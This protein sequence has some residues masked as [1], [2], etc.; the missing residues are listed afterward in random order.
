VT[1]HHDDPDL[2]ELTPEDQ[3]NAMQNDST[4]FSDLLA[5][6]GYRDGD[7]LTVNVK[8]DG[9]FTTAA[10]SPLKQIAYD[11]LQYEGE[12]VDLWFGLN[13][14]RSD[15]HDGSRGKDSDITAV[16][17]FNVDMDVKA[18]AFR[19][20]GELVLMQGVVEGSGLVPTA[21][22]RTGHGLC[23][24]W[25]VRDDSADIAAATA[26]GVRLRRAVESLA[27]PMLKREVRLDNTSSVTRIV[28]VPGTTNW[29]DA[30][31]PAPTSWEE[32][33]GGGMT[34]T[35][36]GLA[37]LLDEMG[38]PAH[39]EDAD[40]ELGD[41]ADFD[42]WAFAESG[43]GYSATMTRNW[44]TETPSARHPWLINKMVRLHCAAR[45][46]CLTRRGYELAL[47]GVVDR[48]E[49][50]C[51]NVEPRRKPDRHE[52]RDAVRYG[53]ARAAGKTTEQLSRELGDHEHD[54]TDDWL[55]TGTPGT[56]TV[57]S[58]D[59]ET[60]SMEELALSLFTRSEVL[61]SIH[62]HAMSRLASPLAVLGCCMIKALA[63]APPNIV[64]AP[65]IG[66]VA[67]PN[68]YLALVGGSGGG[69]GIAWDVAMDE[70]M[71]GGGV[72]VA[73]PST[74]EGL[75][76]MFVK[77]GRGADAEQGG[78]QYRT[79]AVA[80]VD[81]VSTL[82]ALQARSGNKLASTL[83]T[84]W[85]GR[86]GGGFT[87]TTEN[88]IVLPANS[89]RFCMV[90]GVQPSAAGVLFDD[91]GAGTPQRFW[92]MPATD[93]SIVDGVTEPAPLGWSNPFE[94]YDE[95]GHGRFV[96]EVPQHVW[97]FVRGEHVKRQRGEGDAL[98]GHAL[99]SRLK[100]AVAIASLHRRVAVTDED[101]D[102]S[103]D[104]MAISDLVRQDVLDEL[105]QASA[106][107]AKARGFIK[108]VEDEARDDYLEQR[109]AKKVER[110]VRLIATYLERLGPET[111]KAI[112]P[113][114][115]SRDRDV[116]QDAW[117]IALTRG[118]IRQRGD[119]LYEATTWEGGSGGS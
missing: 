42:T 76:A 67:Q 88:R 47:Q 52:V 46:G 7:Y 89:Y 118:L 97:D 87:K 114:I 62:D 91:D 109:R 15:L 10:V 40:H 57:S 90:V 2:N 119:A 115:Q 22:L 36:A 77:P 93:R 29:K 1:V 30:A 21:W 80:Y 63:E 117:D 69:K 68:A 54:D 31:A 112:R 45:A 8:R 101:W 104:F 82:S 35:M 73:P 51:S 64:L 99:L 106:R 100:A 50:L 98:D 26:I 74:G 75:E 56:S 48:F 86:L 107:G 71:P 116:F 66:K 19:D 12:Q 3:S 111:K 4:T 79:Q 23:P 37:A 28:R 38:V 102:A 32:P 49:W 43:C 95:L 78:V 9:H 41:E 13:P 83:R 70:L 60:R 96:V 110:V 17:A 16:R 61:Q 53:K 24:L 44:M 14:V 20:E 25:A 81:E 59:P 34:W 85:S 72:F 92:W 11:V 55:T 84:L 18:G 58:G 33:A 5:A 113:R 39:Q 65:I 105:R 6:M 108:A 103:G 27:E 94:A